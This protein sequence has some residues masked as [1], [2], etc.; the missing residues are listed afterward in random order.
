MILV[1]ASESVSVPQFLTELGLFFIRLEKLVL[2][3][4]SENRRNF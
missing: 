1:K 4:L 2:R 3:Y